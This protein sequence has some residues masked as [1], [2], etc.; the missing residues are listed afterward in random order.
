MKQLKANTI[1]WLNA[2]D[3]LERDLVGSYNITWSW[4]QRDIK[5]S[6]VSLHRFVWGGD[7]GHSSFGR[8]N[9]RSPLPSCWPHSGEGPSRAALEEP[10]NCVCLLS[11]YSVQLVFPFPSTN[12][13]KKDS[14]RAV[15]VDQN[16]KIAARRPSSEPK[17]IIKLRERQ[18]WGIILCRFISTNDQFHIVI[19]FIIS[20]IAT[21]SFISVQPL[22]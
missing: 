15:R 17:L 5:I 11:R 12:L 3:M 18:I 20:I 6:Q 21:S 13:R 19:W 10:H 22:K 16:R 14:T 8:G 1:K 2:A 9:E 4:A 7:G